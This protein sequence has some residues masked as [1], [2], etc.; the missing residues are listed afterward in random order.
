MCKAGFAGSAPIGCGGGVIADLFAEHDRASA[1]ALFSL[2]PLMGAFRY[3][4]L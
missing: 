2:G 4:P 1:T 3:V